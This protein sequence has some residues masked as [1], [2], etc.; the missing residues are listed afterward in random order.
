MLTPALV[1]VWL[2]PVYVVIFVFGT[3]YDA[4]RIVFLLESAEQCDLSGGMTYNFHEH[5]YMLCQVQ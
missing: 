1:R 5:G 3:W 2:D 4:A